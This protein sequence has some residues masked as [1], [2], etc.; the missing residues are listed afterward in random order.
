MLTEG[1]HLTVSPCSQL[2]IHGRSC[3]R[4]LVLPRWDALPPLLLAGFVSCG[5]S[6]ACSPCG[7]SIS[8][9]FLHRQTIV[10]AL[11]SASLFTDSYRLLPPSSRPARCWSPLLTSMF[12]RL[13]DRSK[14]AAADF[15]S[16]GGR[17]G[18]PSPEKALKFLRWCP[19]RISP[20]S[21]KRYS[22]EPQDPF[23]SIKR[24][25]YG[26]LSADDL[27]A[28]ASPHSFLDDGDGPK[29]ACFRHSP[30]GGEI[31]ATARRNP[32]A[33]RPSEVEG[34]RGPEAKMAQVYRRRYITDLCLLLG[35]RGRQP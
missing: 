1:Q 29:A 23:P 11:E 27:P 6:A 28:S 7:V 30:S 2:S 15:Y 31:V 20:A 21:P 14:A 8:I 12:N 13:I 17:S 33:R 24:K 26:L 34:T 4:R 5:S 16:R 32:N 9:F 22:S 10:P 25:F 3:F 19:R 35:R 18:L